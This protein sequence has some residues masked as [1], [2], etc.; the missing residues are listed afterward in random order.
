[1]GLYQRWGIAKTKLH[2]R[3][4]WSNT[5]HYNKRPQSVSFSRYEP[6]RGDRLIRTMI[7]WIWLGDRAR[8]TLSGLISNLA[9]V[10]AVG[11]E[12]GASS[13]DRPSY[14]GKTAF[15]YR[16]LETAMSRDQSN[17]AR[18][19]DNC[20]TMLTRIY[21]LLE[22]SRFEFLFNRVLR[23]ACSTTRLGY[24]SARHYWDALRYRN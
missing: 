1:M 5:Q 18:A 2:F 10:P 4:L 7:R 11:L 20:S 14:F 17:S 8:K 15:R 23:V 3:N 6:M 9:S 12:V 19:R 13:A 21:R 22:D 16:H 24:F